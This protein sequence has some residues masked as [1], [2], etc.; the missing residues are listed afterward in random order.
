MQVPDEA[1]LQQ[2]EQQIEADDRSGRA[3]IVDEYTFS[4]TKLPVVNPIESRFRF[5]NGR[6]A[7][8]RDA[9]DARQWAEQAIGGVKGWLAGRVRPLRA[10]KAARKLRP[11][12]AVGDGQRR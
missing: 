11:Y 1:R 4:D 8:H 5:E 2:L 6:I 7:E 3:R 9:C 12:L 10:W